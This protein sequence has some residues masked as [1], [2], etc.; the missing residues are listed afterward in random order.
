VSDSPV[1]IFISYARDDEV[2]PPEEPDARGFVTFLHEQVDYIFRGNGHP[3]PK[4][5]RD[6][7]R[8]EK[9]AQFE[10]MIEDAINASS[11]LVVVL[12]KNW[13]ASEWCRRELD[14]FAK[15]W[16]DDKGL[17]ERIVVV[18]KRH[19]DRDRRPSLI[20]GQEGYLFYSLNDAHDVGFEKEFFKRGKVCDP[21]YYDQVEQLAAY[22]WR[23][24]ERVDARPN[25]GIRHPQGLKPPE[26][27]PPN[28]RT[29]YLAK[30]ASDMRSNYDRMVRELLGRG[31]AVVPNPALDIPIDTTAVSF[32]DDA[33]AQA[34]I[35]IHLLGEMHGYTPEEQAP[36]VELQLMRAGERARNA[37]D[38]S[39][40]KFRRIAWAPKALDFDL[41]VTAQ[42]AERDPA[43]VLE[44]FGRPLPTDKIIGESLNKFLDFLKDYLVKTARPNTV[45]A[46]EVAGSRVF[47]YHD[48]VDADYAASLADLLESRR[49][50]PVF[51]AFEGS[52]ADLTNFH[53]KQLASCDAVVVCWAAASEVWARSATSEL[54]DWHELGR[55]TKFAYRSVIAG[56]PPGSRKKSAKRAFPRNEVDVVLDLTE[57]GHSP[58]PDSLDPLFA[59]PA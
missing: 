36:I 25:E 56:P 13:M 52:P 46:S 49:A 48:E 5:W 31:Y 50:E 21:R 19:V 11:I 20:Q 35:S 23:R 54:R 4:I 33:L 7:I 12:S 34:E 28:G 1:Q 41:P 3:R 24:A 2:P 51:P 32:I 27:S 45:H 8:I 22:L 43:A 40:R 53:R 37:T 14:I 30:P 10:P 39:E 47:L 9:A 18:G 57:S 44:R 6:K 38:V 55:T 58:P 29:V 17:R 16:K 15:C 42:A 26:L 59:A